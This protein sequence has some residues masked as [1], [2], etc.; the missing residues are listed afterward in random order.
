LRRGILFGSLPR[1]GGKGKRGKEGG[2]PK[3]MT[4]PTTWP[5]PKTKGKDA[6]APEPTDLFAFI[7]S[8]EGEKERR[9]K[10]RGENHPVRR[11]PPR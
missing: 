11:T 4:F 9:K 1:E 3:N 10:K 5:I 6:Q 8:R 7:A 2:E